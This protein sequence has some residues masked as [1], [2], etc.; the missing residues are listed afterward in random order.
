MTLPKRIEWPEKARIAVVLQVPCE[1]FEK[2]TAYAGRMTNFPL[3]SKELLEKGLTD[4]LLMSH[5]EYGELGLSRLTELLDKHNVTA[6]GVFSGLTVQRFQ[7]V[8]KAFKKGVGGREVVAHSWAQDIRSYNLDKEQMRANVRKCVDIITKVTGERPVGWV[9]P[10]G[11]RGEHTLPVLAE[12]GF[13]WHGDYNNCDGPFTLESQGK[14]LAG[15]Q[16]PY[17]IND[18]MYIEAKVPPSHY[19]EMFSRAFDVLYEAGGQVLGAVAHATVY[20]HP[21]GIWA[22]DQVIKYA[23]GFPKVWF[24]TRRDVA[25]WYLKKYA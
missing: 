5:D 6:S 2:A 4:Y 13:I 15:M 11:Q 12:E 7:D 22:Y 18:T 9:S 17:D 10:G 20:G 16:V 25:E 3:L 23:K 8:V 14:K 19:V 1:Q 24:A 21:Y